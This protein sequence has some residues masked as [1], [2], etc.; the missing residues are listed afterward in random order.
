MRNREIEVKIQVSDVPAL[1]VRLKQLGFVRMHARALEDNL[2]FDTPDRKLRAVRSVL[3]L[4]RYQGEWLVTYKGTPEPDPHYKSRLELESHLDNPQSVHAIFAVLGLVPV[5]RYQKYRSKYGPAKGGRWTGVEVA[6]D[7][8][9]I[10][11][12]IELE[13][14]RR[15]IDHVARALGYSKSDY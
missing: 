14:T 7:E 10:G 2:L 15:G 8:T 13:G 6:L 12:F 9:P 3:R 4:R 1:R 5:F 11:E